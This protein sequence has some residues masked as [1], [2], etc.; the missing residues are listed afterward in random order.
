[1]RTIRSEPRG[2]GLRVA[3][4][5][6]RWHPEIVD[7]LLQ[8]ALEALV[9][10]GVAPSDV[11]TVEVPGSYELPQAAMRIA[12]AG[13]VDAIVA[14]GCVIR[15]ETPHAEVLE[16]AC[17]QGL[18]DVAMETGVPT[19]FGVVTASTRAQAEERSDP[20]RS[21]KGGHKGVEAAEAAVRLARALRGYEASP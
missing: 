14:L 18:L 7:R 20:A 8:G 11:V 13:R 15:G 17:A 2:E 19:G 10:L 21:G 6:A 1:M 16:R 4:L 3:V 9:R 5:A 12:R